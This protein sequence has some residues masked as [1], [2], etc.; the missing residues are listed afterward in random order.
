MLVEDE[1]RGACLVF[2]LRDCLGVALIPGS[3]PRACGSLFL[4]FVISTPG[5]GEAPR[6]ICGRDKLSLSLT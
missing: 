5:T 2:L 3:I 1:F 6:Q 4:F